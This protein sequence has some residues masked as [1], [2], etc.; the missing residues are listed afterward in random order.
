MRVCRANTPL[1]KNGG[2]EILF[3]QVSTDGGCTFAPL[4]NSPHYEA[5]AAAHV[6]SGKN[7][8]DIC[9]I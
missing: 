5:L 3:I 8:G 7:F 1:A 2:R 4:I 9:L 6:A